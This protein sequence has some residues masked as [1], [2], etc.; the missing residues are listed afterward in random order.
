S[1]RVDLDPALLLAAPRRFLDYAPPAPTPSFDRTLAFTIERAG[2]LR[3]F[4]GWFEA[5][6]APGVILANRP[7]VQ[8]HWGQ[9]LFP[10]PL[11]TVAAGDEV[12]F[13]VRA[14]DPLALG[15]AWSLEIRRGGDRVEPDPAPAPRA[16]DPEDLNELGAAA[17]AAG[18]FDEARVVWGGAVR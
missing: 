13:A 15:L 10:V 18:R 8:T 11:H 9:V 1:Y 16:G 5:E 3:A 14:L 7:G 4:A 6:L 2:P 17:F 12:R